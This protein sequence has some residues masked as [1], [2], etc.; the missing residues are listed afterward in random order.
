MVMAVLLV[1]SNRYLYYFFFMQLFLFE[2]LSKP[3]QDVFLGED[4]LNVNNFSSVPTTSPPPPFPLVKV[5]WSAPIY[6]FLSFSFLPYNYYHFTSPQYILKCASKIS[7]SAP[8]Q[9]YP[10]P[11]AIEPPLCLQLRQ[12]LL[13]A[14]LALVTIWGGGLGQHCVSV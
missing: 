9:P 12:W 5:P 3:M 8:Q 1:P 4:K 13:L 10:L 2:R 11:Q 14:L 7:L 6:P